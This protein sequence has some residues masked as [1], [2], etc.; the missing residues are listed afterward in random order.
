LQ[1]LR[2]KPFYVHRF[3]EAQNAG[4]LPAQFKKNP[5]QTK[6]LKHEDNAYSQV[7]RSDGSFVVGGTGR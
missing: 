1:V 5:K 2:V 4:I 3:R 6:G 7:V